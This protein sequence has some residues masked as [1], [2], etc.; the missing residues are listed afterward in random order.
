MAVLVNLFC[1][2]I[3]WKMATAAFLE[4]RDFVGWLG[5]VISAAN[6][7]AALSQMI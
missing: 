1:S 2:W 5:L 3:C 6:F 7:E 4:E